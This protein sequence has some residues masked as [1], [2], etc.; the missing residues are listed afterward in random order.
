MGLSFSFGGSSGVT[1]EQLQRQQQ[2]ARALM[3]QATRTPRNAGEGI[4]AIGNAL[5][6]RMMDGRVQR[7]EADFA[8]ATQQMGE[9]PDMIGGAPTPEA[10]IGGGVSPEIMQ[11]LMGGKQGGGQ[12]PAG[13]MMSGGGQAEI[14]GGPGADML[15]MP[16]DPRA[17]QMPMPPV[18]PAQAPGAIMG[19]DGQ[20][21]RPQIG[22]PAMPASASAQGQMTPETAPSFGI[23]PRMPMQADLPQ[24]DIA[25]SAPQGQ[26]MQ[27]PPDAAAQFRAMTPQGQQRFMQGAQGGLSPDEAMQP[28]G[29][30]PYDPN[31]DQGALG[32]PERIIP[33]QMQLSRGAGDTAMT[34]QTYAEDPPP[35]T[36]ELVELG[37]NVGIESNALRGLD[38][39]ATESRNFGYLLRMMDAEA[40]IRDLEGSNTWMQRILE[41]LPGQDLESVFMDPEYRRYML[42]RENFN[43][44]ALR[45]ATGATI[46]DQEMPRQ[47]Q[48]Y[49]PL[50]N[51]DAE[52]RDFL[53]RQRQALMMALM[54]ASGPGSALVP[55]FGQPVVPRQARGQATMRFNPETGQLEPIQ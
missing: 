29:F 34:G 53:Q 26:G 54:A 25:V 3:Q 20:T 39:N 13:A 40:T 48:N 16:Q 24:T 45:A 21:I 17:P 19:Y 8:K 46:N 27:L 11:A 47:R 2:L 4:G 41:Y 18:T 12:A 22:S 55:E 9:Q 49:F 51:D 7:G 31:Q 44:P 32:G 10:A 23:Q 38:L 28:E 33:A 1:Q 50:P 14:A 15:S 5:L 36:D 43:E 30:L 37:V 52:T 6:Y 35:T 42:A